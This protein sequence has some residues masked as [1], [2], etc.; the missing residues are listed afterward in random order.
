MVDENLISPK[1]V[2]VHM[3]TECNLGC[4]HCYI[5]SIQNRAID[6]EGLQRVADLACELGCSVEISGG[7]PF[8]C[9][10]TVGFVSNLV[11][12]GVAV[13]AVYT[14]GTLVR[15]RQD[16]V[17][18]LL[19]G[20]DPAPTFLVSLDGWATEHDEFRGTGTYARALD[21]IRFLV[22]QGARVSVNTMLHRGIGLNG[23]MRL[24]RDVLQ[25]GVHRWR[26]DTPFLAGAWSAH[27]FL[28]ELPKSDVFSLFNAVLQEWLK[29][30]QPFELE[31]DHVLKY[32]HGQFYFLDA[33]SLDDVVCPCRVLTIWP[34]SSISWCQNLHGKCGVIGT[35]SDRSHDLLF[36][37]M[38]RKSMT[39]NTLLADDA[40]TECRNC[41]FITHCALGC[42]AN[43]ILAGNS[44]A[45]KD[46]EICCLYR[47]KLYKLILE[48]L[49]CVRQK[50]DCKLA[51]TDRNYSPK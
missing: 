51:F 34:D 27:H 19:S 44:Y 35:L 8:L 33:Y 30:G 28:A 50:P 15:F 26:I 4:K 25:S 13:S 22:N 39:I 41:D 5:A 11:S 17:S 29:Q 12:K 47:D 48:T 18:Q 24:F 42:R 32:I 2:L 36:N 1:R 9:T 38:Q 43:A 14:N 6:K 49:R 21:G 31:I 7:E 3:S 23:L 45:S 46:E 37:Y 20:F 40:F 10:A 16:L